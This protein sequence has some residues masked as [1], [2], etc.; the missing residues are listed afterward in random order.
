MS[1]P[2]LSA[3]AAVLRPMVRAVFAHAIRLHAEKSAVHSS[4]RSR[5]LENNLN[6]TLARLRGGG[7]ED[8]W[9][10]NVLA[11][12]GH[13]YVT[14][15]FLRRP[16]LQEW[17]GDERLAKDLKVLARDVIMGE[18]HSDAERRAR[19]AES[20]SNHTGEEIQ[21]AEGPID[22]ITAILVAGYVASIP[23]D[24]R[25]LAGMFQELY[26]HLNSRFDNLEGNRL[27]DI[28]EFL[29]SQFPLVQQSLTDHAERELSNILRF[30]A[31]NEDSS[32]DRLRELL[33]RI[34][35]GDLLG[36]DNATKNRIRYWTARYC[37]T[38]AETLPL[39]R[40]LSK[41]LRLA[42]ANL[43]LSVV[44][45]LIAERDGDVDKALRL[46]RG[47]STSDTQSA[48]FNLLVRV[49]GENGAM[50]WFKA[51]AGRDNAQFFTPVG[52]INWAICACELQM[53]EE[54]SD[55]LI[56]LED[57]WNEM[58]KL[59]LIEGTINAAMLLP[60][61]F[62]RMI[63]EGVPLYHGMS[64][65]Q[66]TAAE[67]RHS[68]ATACFDFVKGSIKDTDQQTLIDFVRDWI[69]WLR[70]MHPRRDAVGDARD[71]IAL[72]MQHGAEAVKAIL[73]SY[74]FEIEFDAEPL[75]MYLEERRGLGGL[76]GQELLAECLLFE[77]TMEPEDFIN[78]LENNGFA[79]SEVMPTQSLVGMYV[80][81]LV[82]DDQPPE[83]AR[84]FIEK[85]GE[86][87][88]ENSDRLVIFI[89]ADQGK[90]LRP[91]LE[92]RYKKTQNFVDLKN[93]IA[94]LK[95]EGDH[96]ALQP[97]VGIQFSRA[98][99]V[100]SALDVVKCLS[101]PG[102]YDHSSI[103]AFL[104][105]NDDIAAQ[106]DE[107]QTE[108]ALALFHAGRVVDA[109]AINDSV[110]S[111]RSHPDNAR[112]DL[113]I[114]M[115]TGDWER[116]GAT[117]DRAW[118]ERSSYDAEA[119][120]SF[121]HLAGQHGQMQDRALELAR[122]AVARAP[123]DPRILAAAYWQYFQLGHDDK[124][125]PSWLL[126]ASEL[127]SAEE[128]PI[129]RVD[130][131]HFAKE[132]LPKRRD[133]LQEV[134]RMWLNGEIPLS[135][136]A[137]RFNVSLARLLLHVP[138]QSANEQ[139]G[140]RRLLLPIISGAHDPV[141]LQDTWTIGVDVTSVMVL[142]YLGLLET[143][144]EAFHHVKLAPDI[145]EHLFRERDEVRF[146]QPSRIADAKQVLAIQSRGQL[147][148]AGNLATPP[149]FLVDEVGGEL[150]GLLQMARD[151]NGKV[152]CILPLYRVGSLMEQKAD[153][154]A[155]DDVIISITDFC[156]LLRGT[157]KIGEADYQR[158]RT[159]FLGQGQSEK[160]TLSPSILES[161]IYLDGLAL[162]YLQD[163]KVLQAVATSGTAL[164]IH[165]RIIDEMRAYIE[166]GDAVQG[167]M[168]K[169][170]RIRHVLRTAIDED[171]A[172]FLPRVANQDQELQIG[173]LRF[174]ATA[175]LLEGSG[176]YDAVCV[177][178][179]YING[180]QTLLGPNERSV[181]I[182]CV[183]DVL[184][185][186]LSKGVLDV[187]EYRAARHKLRQGGFGFIAL[188]SEDLLYWLRQE[189]L[190]SSEYLESK[191]L[192]VLRQTAAG[193]D[194]LELSNWQE[195]FALTAAS[196]TA[197]SKA[198]L[199]LWED[200][201]LEPAHAATLCDWVWRNLMATALPGRQSLT[202]KSYTNLIREVVSLRVGSLLLPMPSRPAERQDHYADW[203]EHS[204]LEP[205]RPANIERIES[206]LS[207]ARD[208]IVNLDIDQEAYGNLFLSR[209]PESARR[210]MINGDP[211]FARKCGF[212]SESVFSI[213]KRI[214]LKDS[215][216]FAS[217]EQV[218]AE[219]KE[220]AIED[221]SGHHVV[222]AL[223]AE[224]ERIVVKWREADST[225]S[226][227]EIASLSV[228]STS[229]ESRLGMLRTV[230]ADLGPT[231]VDFSYLLEEIEAR[232]PTYEE[233][234][235]IFDEAA[236]G[237][238]AIQRRLKDRIYAR[239]PLGGS[240]FVPQSLTYYR[241]FAGPSPEVDDP[242]AY[243]QDTLVSY[244]KALLRKDF[245][246]GLDIC[247]LGAL[248]DDLCPGDWILGVDD[249]SVWDALPVCMPEANPFS[250]LG[251][252]DIALYRQK[253]DRFVEFVERAIGRLVDADFG[254]R[255]DLDVYG[256]LHVFREY[257]GN[258]INLLEHGSQQPGYW[259][260]LA[261]WMQAG[262]ITRIMAQSAF[263]VDMDGLRAWT[264]ENMLAAG[265]Y[266][267]F[268]DA[269][270]EPMLFA[271][272]AS[273]EYLRHEVL[274]RLHMLKVRHEGEG[275]QHAGF[276]RIDDALSK[277]EAGGLALALGLPGPLEGHKRPT[278]AMPEETRR[279][280][281]E[282]WLGESA[283]LHSLVTASQFFELGAEELQRARSTV[284]D[285]EREVYGSEL[286]ENFIQLEL[287]SI[288]ASANR[289]RQLGD[290]IATAVIGM[291]SGI[292]TEQDIQVVLRIMLQAAAANEDHEEW[293]KW[294]EDKL[295][296]I[297]ARIPSTP[298]P[299]LNIFIGH[300]GE[301]EVILPA[302]SWFHIRAKSR[303]LAGAS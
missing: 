33:R 302:D 56:I 32:R 202:H 203:T 144:V 87:D 190:E 75:R 78:Y 222:I 236:N 158:A 129:W 219:K 225:P 110:L 273:P 16:S 50:E 23:E 90:D 242:E 6:E 153:T 167:L 46:L 246:A 224:N 4:I 163:A 2:S 287:A 13:A 105:E 10:S 172:S 264:A 244:R 133:H 34:D 9:W 29:T 226:E 63:L 73:F 28:Q 230:I 95:K 30:R 162:R 98:P 272:S 299:L 196:R 215:N 247:C 177:D 178:D 43:D 93:L 86:L 216:L 301:L 70:L 111:R 251:A 106:S 3:L 24:Q 122:L 71:Q 113:R 265:T 240:D 96:E 101:N 232:K 209:L 278:R 183:L 175:S 270:R 92:K 85:H 229:G 280:L 140:R 100:E 295:A 223:N 261:A 187:S 291:C 292:S 188:D 249:N 237:V 39:A 268:V 37:A 126:Q 181:P 25:P 59:A 231:A 281:E 294:L 38:E 147:E 17:L 195:A 48:L 145:M 194:S 284:G 290:C 19:L 204:V 11:R 161:P 5:L 76:E 109:R 69:V 52:W 288:V 84:D 282:V 103:I 293:F 36:A 68:R 79:L 197:C 285:M 256:L 260:R 128:G 289:D 179:R 259:K 185:Y 62:R 82:E 51:Q 303:S 107:L 257:V 97:F 198:I 254:M 54:A 212:Q 227:I 124:A 207:A 135:L 83:K 221:V 243:L 277:V 182:V 55:R 142:S 151:E 114:A 61:D 44:D 157:G 134:E 149:S 184:C 155:F 104:E 119:L 176:A 42:N 72:R 206:A 156:A 210:A 74:A 252:L 127:S 164:R 27:S 180:H 81:A 45:A 193:A 169:L 235:S 121:A 170:E 41:E 174:Q 166:E 218:F 102:N 118:E 241:R 200:T 8:S 21:L 146:H 255:D 154:S 138:R 152:I 238:S 267:G 208:V 35:E 300:L 296:E 173:T 80:E 67:K 115:A 108:K 88:E 40:K 53:W 91:Q 253:D 171:N 14:P 148:V 1:D 276:R 22:V 58:P 245:E 233:L 49:R 248:R 263:P 192:R 250:L 89:D 64:A 141:E 186:L 191:E 120:I 66:G 139:D 26:G 47:A 213:G 94:Y 234:S 15:D 220:N 116:I 132:W 297:A 283:P 31:F 286:Q 274:G 189:K 279:G 211:E 136:A 275:R 199:G 18:V 125:D 7:I 130:L 262:L 159:F 269:R 165:Q 217:A 258:R 214:Q 228:L 60:L 123:E 160:E 12:I 137:G 201:A 205:L 112:L 131:R 266:A 57:Y 20:Y 271:D 150:A 168:T 143:A 117:L 77:I 239:S 99:T 65:N 298:E